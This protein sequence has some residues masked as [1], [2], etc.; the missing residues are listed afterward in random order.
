MKR[1]FLKYIYIT[2]SLTLASC[3]VSKFIPEDHYLLDEVKLV[4]ENKEV[5]P[6]SVR[7]YVRQNPNAKWFSLVK[8]PLYTYCLSGKDSTKWYN[9]FFRRIGD[10]PVIYDEEAT[11]RSEEELTKALNNMG[12]MSASVSAEKKISKKKLKLTYKLNPGKP[13]MIRDVH[14]DIKDRQ[15]EQYLLMDSANMKMHKGMIFDVNVLDAERQR[16]TDYLL[17]HGY[18]KFNKDF[19]YYT[20]DTARNT[21]LVDVTLHLQPYKAFQ[22]D[23]PKDHYQ[24][25]INK[26]S[27]ITDYDVLK[28]SALT[29]ININDSVHYKDY[30]IY[31]KDKLFIRP[32]VLVDNLHISSG[33]LYNEQNVQDTYAYF[34]RLRALKYTNIR[35]AEIENNDSTK[36]NCYVMLTK[37]KQ[38]SV[39]AELEGTNSAGDLGAAASVSFQHRNLFKGSEIFTIKLRGA[40]EAI[41]GLQGYSNDN[42]TEY[43]V[44]TS[45]NFPC[46]LFP[47]LSSEFKRNIRATSEVSIQYNSQIR[48]EFART[49]ASATWSY[50]WTMRKKAQHKVDLLDINYVYMPRIEKK[51]K[52]EYLDSMSNSIL[53]YNYEN[54]LIVKMGYSYHYNS[55]GG[56]F[57]N[58]TASKNSYSIRLNLESAGN[59]FYGISKLIKQR[60][61]DNRYAIWNIAY[62]QY[63]KGDFDF[64]KNIAIDNRNSFAFHVG[65]G[66]A[67]P[68]GNSDM[69]PFEKR[70]FSGGANSVRGWGVRTLGPGSF[71]GEDK[72]IDFMNQSGDVKLDLNVEYRTRLFWKLHGAAFVDAGNIWT[73]RDYKEQPGGQFRFN[74]FY[75][76]IAVAYG[77]GIRFDFDFVVLRF[78][79]GMKAV[80][81][82]YVTQKEH[83]PLIHPKFSRDFAFHFAVGYPF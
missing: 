4:S 57:V 3:S 59:I 24:Y 35:F 31:F 52:E 40:Y 53:K 50:K 9:K 41:T 64:S 47:F 36:L 46:F 58:N 21:Y 45:L 63:V 32:K 25:K 44:E 22:N 78:D 68:Y 10:A 55:I 62:A 72:N 5:K 80:N 43:G 71:K 74:T 7:S 12:Y 28:S 15:I 33:S 66:I 2:L 82:A 29:S 8:V 27:F 14:Y 76:Q 51:F 77:L 79:G 39:S 70:Y 75:K 17:R 61:M 81:P 18:Y 42:Y 65:L 38:K 60:K 54:L 20:A 34:G 23:N 1:D 19:I 83:F 26:I 6:S 16:I 49:V 56:A 13:Y 69:L 67:Y 73:I 11:E 48:P 30:P 37:G